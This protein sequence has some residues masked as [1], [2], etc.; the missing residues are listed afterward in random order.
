MYNYAG[1]L[2][3]GDNYVRWASYD[4][5]RFYDKYEEA[6]KSYAIALGAYGDQDDILFRFL[7]V[8]IRTDNRN[9][10]LRLKDYFEANPKKAVDP[11]RYAELGGYL[12]DK[13][14]S[15]GEVRAILFRA[16]QAD[17]TIP[18]IHYHLARFCNKREEA[19]DER[20]ALNNAIHLYGAMQPVSRRGLWRLVDSYGR[21][22]E[23]YAKQRSFLEAEG[24]YR[25]G[26]ERYEDG[27][28]KTLVKKDAVLGRLYQRLGDI[29]YYQSGDLEAAY[30][31]FVKA[32]DSLV[33]DPALYYKKGFI[34]YEQT[35]YA[36]A[37]REFARTEESFPSSRNLLFALGNANYLRNNFSVSEGYYAYLTER[38]E[39]DR[40][41]V[42]E[43]L[44]E[45]RSSDRA[46]LLN[47]IKAYNNLGVILYKM[48]QRTGNTQNTSRAMVL[49]TNSTQ[50]A[51]NYAR[52]RESLVRRDTKDLAYLN[53]RQI[54]TPL[55]DYELQI[56]QQLPRDMSEQI[57]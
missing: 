24:E 56:Y 31:Q 22:G 16:L 50:L 26:I 12:L 45:D 13:N 36:A 5:K 52:D 54:L 35:D 37:L 3:A 9:E 20:I 32:E 53:L 6:R 40:R 4:E 1:L 44:P 51:T 49:W 17:K 14:E 34:S 46:L 23:L 8:F 15:L 7:D 41:R 39:A 47:L 29:Y 11:V 48:G 30:A 2:E 19:A 42:G 10:V 38:L 33:S 55:P 57:F 27:V 18:D 28:K 43:L 25:Q 21:S